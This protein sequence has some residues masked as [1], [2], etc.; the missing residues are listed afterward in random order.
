MLVTTET[1]VEGRIPRK[2]RGTTRKIEETGLEET[3]VSAMRERTMKDAI[4]QDLE[5]G[6]KGDENGR[7]REI[8]MEYI[9]R[10]KG[11]MTGNENVTGTETMIRAIDE[12]A[13]GIGATIDTGHGVVKDLPQVIQLN[14]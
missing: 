13:R 10:T 4:D 7:G 1:Q 2:T 14:Y 12:T 5:I 6:E 3:I 11:A 8:G 9:P